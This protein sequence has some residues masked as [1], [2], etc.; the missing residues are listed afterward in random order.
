MP[1]GH[2]Q[3]LQYLLQTWSVPPWQ[4]SGILLGYWQDELIWV[5]GYYEHPKYQA[6]E[7]E[8]GWVLAYCPIAILD[9]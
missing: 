5:A 6:K 8:Q 7:D 9:P 1:G 3:S 2:H 4:R